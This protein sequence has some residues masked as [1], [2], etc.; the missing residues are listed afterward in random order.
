[1]SEIAAGAVP[2]GTAGG[3]LAGSYPGPT[4]KQ[5]SQAFA[6]TGVLSPAQITASQNNYNPTNLGVSTV[7]RLSTDATRSLTGL[8]GSAIPWRILLLENVGAHDLVLV[9]ESSS[10]ASANRFALDQDLTLGPNQSVLLQY[11]GTS[12]RWRAVAVALTNAILKSLIDAKGDLIVGTADNTPARVAVGT[13]GQ[14]LS[15]DSAQTAGVRWV[16]PPSGGGG[17][18]GKLY[19]AANWR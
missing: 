9:A 2:S 6:L 19:L 10:S 8:A 7:L 5:A 16:D 1:V 3:D 18:G 4:V 14:I 13:D 12:S 11:D 15:A 17:V